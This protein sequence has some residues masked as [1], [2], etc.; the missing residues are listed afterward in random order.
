MRSLAARWKPGTYFPKT[1]DNTMF[2]LVNNTAPVAREYDAVA[3]VEAHVLV[4]KVFFD[5]G[6]RV[7]EKGDTVQMSPQDFEACSAAGQ[8]APGITPPPAL[9]QP[10]DQLSVYP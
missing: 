5:E 1:K 8:V 9:P 2:Q 7:G 10:A 6:Y 3:T 4:D